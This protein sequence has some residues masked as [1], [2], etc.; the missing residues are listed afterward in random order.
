[1]MIQNRPIRKNHR[2]FTLLEVLLAA[3][4]FSVLLVTFLAI[5]SGTN[6]LTRLAGRNIEAS[7]KIRSVVDRF[8]TDIEHAITTPGA[9]FFLTRTGDNDEIRFLT[10]VDGYAGER[11]I[12]LVSYRL[13]LEPN[14]MGGGEPT[15]VLERAA[16]G[17]TM[18]DPTVKALP[19]DADAPE[20]YDILASGVFRFV[21]QFIGNDG[22][23]ITPNPSGETPWREVQAI[24]V[25]IA[26]IDD[27]AAAIA[28]DQDWPDLLPGDDFSDW[29]DKVEALAFP[30]VLQE[31]ARGIHIRRR[32]IALRG[33]DLL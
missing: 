11:P 15:F 27:R 14:P 26:A 25:S 7:S 31:A 13:R 29:Q 21:L 18:A 10:S 9:S 22:Q 4:V 28:P 8:A 24:I 16:E 6:T 2:A 32:V 19:P 33:N 12:A 3:A 23:L 1:M 30:G 20:E 17:T 5:T